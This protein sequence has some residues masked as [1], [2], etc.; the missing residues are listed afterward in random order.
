MD[1]IVD[2][3]WRFYSAPWTAIAKAS[4]AVDFVAASITLLLIT[5]GFLIA[6]ATIIFM[7]LACLTY[8]VI[9][10]GGILGV[11][12]ILIGIPIA[13]LQ[14]KTNLYLLF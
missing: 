1:F 4:T 14:E 7:T 6:T 5:V 10:I 13:I 3:F 9:L 11:I 8:S 12:T 2:Y